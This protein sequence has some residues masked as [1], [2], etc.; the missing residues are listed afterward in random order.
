[1]NIQLLSAARGVPGRAESPLPAVC[2]NP[3][4]VAHGVK[5]PALIS[6]WLL[7]C[8]CIL[9]SS[10]CLQALGQSY[11]IDWYKVSGGGGTSTGSVYSVTGTIGQ[12]DASGPLSGGQY[13][14]TGG[15]WSLVQVIQTAG[16]PNLTITH[17]GNSIIVSWPAT[18]SYT[19]QQNANVALPSGWA[20]SGYAVATANG[21]N[22]ITITPPTGSIFFRLKQ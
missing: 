11:N 4:A 15:F 7:L 14:V 16:L 2:S 1:M 20:T 17:I 13:S 19:L 18:G 10:F 8:F 3:Q 22:S 5:R 9:P 12:P 21:T 6:L